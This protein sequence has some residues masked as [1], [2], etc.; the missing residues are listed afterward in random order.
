[1]KYNNEAEKLLNV[2]NENIDNLSQYDKYL[3]EIYSEIGKI[4]IELN[5][6]CK[7]EIFYS[8]A[9]TYAK[10]FARNNIKESIKKYCQ[11]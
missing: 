8:K 5:N 3:P 4:H 2:I 9:L 11:C 1:M 10:R 6:I 7:A